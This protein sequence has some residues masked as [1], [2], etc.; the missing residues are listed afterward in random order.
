MNIQLKN[1]KIVQSLSEETTCYSATVYVDGKKAFYAANRG[2]GGADEYHPIEVALFNAASAWAKAQPPRKFNDMELASDLELVISDLITEHLV[3]QDAKRLLKK[4][5]FVEN[6]KVFTINQQYAP[7]L[8]DK[9]LARH[10]KAIILNALT[11]AEA[12]VVLRNAA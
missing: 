6:G 3:Q 9:I 4:I 2:C 10:P 11:L 1:L 7:Q 8:H 12:V 5:A